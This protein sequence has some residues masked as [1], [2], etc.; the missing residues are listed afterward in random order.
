MAPLCLFYLILGSLEWTLVC[1]PIP[2]LLAG[3]AYEAAWPGFG[4]RD[5]GPQ[6]SVAGWTVGSD[7]IRE[8]MKERPAECGPGGGVWCKARAGRPLPNSVRREVLAWPCRNYTFYSQIRWWT[9]SNQFDGHVSNCFVF[10]GFHTQINL[11]FN[12]F[13]L[14]EG[15]LQGCRLRNKSI[16]ILFY[17]HKSLIFITLFLTSEKHL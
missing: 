17:L 12:R 3:L 8:M 4:K 13:I 5:I 11:R 7:D 14:S 10:N 6:C 15:N 16:F 1:F 9:H 2:H